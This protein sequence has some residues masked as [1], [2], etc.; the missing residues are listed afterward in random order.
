MNPSSGRGSSSSARSSGTGGQY[1]PAVPSALSR[2]IR[3]G[4]A[5]QS[6]ALVS[7]LLALVTL[8]L[9]TRKLSPADLGVAE[10]V[11]TFI[12]LGSIVLRGGL[13]EALVRLWFTEDD[14][15][16]RARMART[17]LGTVA[18]V[19]TLVALAG[20]AVRGAAGRRA[21]RPARRGHRPPGDPRALELH[22]PRDGLR[23]AARGGAPE[24]VR[25]GV[26]GERAAHRGAHGD[27]RSSSST[28]AR[29]GYLAGNYAAS[30]VVLVGIWATEA[31]RL[32]RA[33]R[34]LARSSPLLRYGLPIVPAEAA[35][36]ALNV[37]DRAYLLRTES[38]AAAGLF[39]LAVKLATVVIVAVRAFGLAW[40]PLAYSITDDDE[41]RRLYAT[42]TTWYVVLIGLVVLTLALLSR[43]IVDLLAAPDFAAAHEALG[44]V[45]LGWGLYGLALLLVTVAGRARVTTRSAPAAFGGLAANVVALLLLVPPLGIAGA[46][47]ALCV[48]YVVTLAILHLLTRGLFL[49]PFE[50]GRLGHATLVLVVAAL[51]GELLLPVDGIAG[52]ASRHRA[53]RARA[54]RPRSHRIPA[55]RG[56]PNDRT[57]ASLMR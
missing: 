33:R 34:P 28:R 27:A 53:R 51:V 1:G 47:I 54:R 5:Y 41:A 9:Y 10:T 35:V 23:A 48:A 14:A 8:P 6:P 42:V 29:D 11:L 57:I 37:I 2:L 32:G 46:G 31:R 49:V 21:V 52:L 45:A 12:I 40:P 56:A 13:A 3:G 19:T 36:F 25:P 18:V 4:A 17:A 43:W 55:S 38:A 7:G 26:D 44:W 20:A 50:W 16:T 22:E 24:G 30:A 15:E 39:A